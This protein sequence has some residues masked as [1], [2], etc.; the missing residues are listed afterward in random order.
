MFAI[1]D[2]MNISFWESKTLSK[3]NKSC[4]TFCFCDTS[5]LPSVLLFSSLFRE[6]ASL[7]MWVRQVSRQEMP[8]G[9]SSVSSM[10]SG[11]TVSS[12]TLQQNPTLV[13]TRSTLSSTL[14][15]LDVTF[16]ERYMWTWSPQWSVSSLVY[17][18]PPYL[19]FLLPL[20]SSY[21]MWSY[22]SSVSASPST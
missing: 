1:I 7:F 18:Y 10:A 4:F 9:S 21:Y 17:F 20:P 19:C 13:T 3:G 5:K 12:W 14:G 8:A 16:Q 6:S 22:A 15:A 11:L 2:A